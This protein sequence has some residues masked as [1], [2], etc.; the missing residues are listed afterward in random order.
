MTKRRIKGEGSVYRR[1]DGRVVGEYLDANGRKRYIT[2]KTKTKT[3]MKGALRKLLEDRDKGIAYDSENLTVGGYLD[4]WL[5]GVK[6]S[7]RDRT[8][9]RNE[10]VVRLHLKPTIGGVKLDKL[11]ALQ[12]QSMYRKKLASGL[13]ARSVEI[14]HTT[15]HKSLKQAV[16][17]Q[18][19]PRNVAE[20]VTP[21][22]SAKK[23]I[24]PLTRGQIKALLD[25]ARSD[26]LYT[27]YALAVTTGMRNGELLGL[28]WR[29]VDLDGGTLQVRRTVFNGHVN[30]PKNASGSRTIRLSK[31]AIRALKQHRANAAKERISEWVFSTRAGTPISVHN[32]HNRSW[33]PLLKKAGLPETTRMHDLR[34][35]C[36]SLLLAQGIPVKVVSEMAGHAD[37][38]ITLSIYGHVLPD[39]QSTAA[40]GIDEALG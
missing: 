11:N 29:D 4:R 37:V 2:S 30:A 38:S 28:Q 3:E 17:W 35:S 31:L 34:H 9:Q 10:E 8:W 40:D 13:S 33:R 7:V 18:L 19:I 14:I 22:R 20:A 39:M 21:P 23:E 26:K 1:K 32:V 6:G 5:D 36:I 16:R 24:K 25:V 15:L 12:V 27:F